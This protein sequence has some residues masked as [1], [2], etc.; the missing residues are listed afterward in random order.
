MLRKLRRNRVA[1]LL[2]S[3]I[4]QR[5]SEHTTETQ[6]RRI[7]RLRESSTC[8]PQQPLKSYSKNTAF[9]ESDQ[10]YQTSESH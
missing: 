9:H 3:D 2:P 8:G 4:V 10:R 7:R 5:H 6:K 1:F